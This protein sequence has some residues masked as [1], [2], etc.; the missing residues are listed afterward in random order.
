MA[1][2]EPPT[3]DDYERIQAQRQQL[4]TVLRAVPDTLLVMS[5]TGEILVASDI[6]FS[7]LTD[8]DQDKIVGMMIDDL[9]RIDAVFAPLSAL[10]ETQTDTQSGNSLTVNSFTANIVNTTLGN[11]SFECR[12]DRVERDYLVNVSRWQHQSTDDGGAGDSG[13]SGGYVVVMR[14]VT[15]LRKLGRFK[16]EML[17]LVS[18]DLRTPLVLIIG[19]ADLLM[20]DVPADM[21]ELRLFVEGIASAAE[22]MDSM[23]T[24][25][26]RLEKIKSSPLE[27]HEEI[28]LSEVIFQVMK[29]ITPLAAQKQITLNLNIPRGML[30]LV[31]GDRILVRQAMDNLVN[32]AVKYTP[33]GGE[34]TVEATVDQRAQ[35]FNF[36]V[37]DNGIGI[38]EE[39]LPYLF[40]SF[41]RANMASNKPIKGAGLGL[42]LVKNVI[43]QHGGSV[44]VESRVNVGSTFGFWLPLKPTD[45]E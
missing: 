35:R 29:D 24:E 26:L 43:Q 12:S 10:I 28:E 33:N 40:E 11:W 20:T 41:F 31:I 23:L 32:N 30:P 37:K 3:F 44:W 5:D 6:L 25:M 27:L 9:A 45:E 17:R 18:H 4:E 16:D 8:L 2:T 22:R 38:P 15:V 1:I 21:P 34:V 14:D 42:S 36:V 39:D 19:Y 7:I 13:E